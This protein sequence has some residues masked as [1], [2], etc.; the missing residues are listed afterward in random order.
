MMR[1]FRRVTSGVSAP[2]RVILDPYYQESNRLNSFLR[3]V[4]TKVPKTNNHMFLKPFLSV[5]DIE[6]SQLAPKHTSARSA[7]NPLTAIQCSRTPDSQSIRY[8]SIH[9][10]QLPRAPALALLRSSPFSRHTFSA[11]PLAIHPSSAMTQHGSDK[12]SLEKDLLHKDT[13]SSGATGTWLI[14]GKRVIDDR[15]HGY[16]V[17]YEP[18]KTPAQTPF[19]LVG[20]S[21]G[22]IAA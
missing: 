14:G 18:Q 7:I 19:A 11:L 3:R 12:S 10:H 13:S 17:C 15:W 20:V 8:R 16:T 1:F 5:L 6:I 21:A 2:L 22:G 9:Q 4:K